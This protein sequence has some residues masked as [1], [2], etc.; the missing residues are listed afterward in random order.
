MKRKTLGRIANV[1]FFLAFLCVFPLISSVSNQLS[2]PS[3]AQAK[4]V[5]GTLGYETKKK[6]RQPG[7]NPG[8]GPLEWVDFMTVEEDPVWPASWMEPVLPHSTLCH[9]MLNTSFARMEKAEKLYASK[10]RMNIDP[11]DRLRAS[12]NA[13]ANMARACLEAIKPT[14]RNR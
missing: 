2:G 10:D 13:Y 6:C 8:S 1:C 7:V 11:A 9:Q 12:A 3:V 5:D 14:G 4:P